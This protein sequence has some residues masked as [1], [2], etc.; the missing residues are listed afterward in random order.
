MPVKP[1]AAGAVQLKVPEDYAEL[2]SAPALPGLDLADAAAYAPGGK[3][4]GRAVSF[5]QAEANDSTLLPEQFRTVLGLADGEVPDR[6]AVKL[7]PD[8]LQA[9]RYE[10]LEPEGSS[11]RATV[12][13]SPTSE[14]VATVACLALPADAAAFKGECEAIA[15][16]LQIT[17][18][19]A[20][21]VGPDPAYAKTLGTIFGKLGGQVANG[22]KA[23]RPRRA[24][25]R[26]AGG[27]RARYPGRVRRRGEAAARHGDEPGG[28]ADQRGDRRAARRGGRRLEAGGRSRG[29]QGQERLR[30]RERCDQAGAGQP[31]ERRSSG[32]KT[33]GYELDGVKRFIPSAVVDSHAAGA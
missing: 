16:T 13:A 17:S 29:G 3:E 18:G 9:Y 10:G 12:Y 2:A 32:L 22:R 6:T 23:D 31:C 30:P 26:R 8:E 24:T 15:D 5:G 21:P 19:N 4:G 14:G 7:G 25:F 20:F 28:C 33:I 11:R 1:V 27:R